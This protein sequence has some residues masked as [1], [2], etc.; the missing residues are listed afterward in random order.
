MLLYF[1]KFDIP[2]WVYSVEEKNNIINVI[3]FLAPP[4]DPPRAGGGEGRGAPALWAR[5]RPAP[6]WWAGIYLTLSYYFLQL[7]IF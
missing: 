7:L 2:A 1:V 6:R 4:G 5:P 3:I